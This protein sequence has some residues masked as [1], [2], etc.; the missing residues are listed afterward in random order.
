MTPSII[1]KGEVVWEV[2]H[3][4]ECA[5]FGPSP[6]LRLSPTTCSQS[7]SSDMRAWWCKCVYFVWPSV[8][9]CPPNP[10]TPSASRAKTAAHAM[11][12]AP[13]EDAARRAEEHAP[14]AHYLALASSPGQISGAF[15]QTHRLPSLSTPFF[16]FLCGQNSRTNI[17]RIRDR[18][19]IRY[20]RD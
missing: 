11:S 20:L 1:L 19:Y 4:L 13:Q 10:N 3:S 12:Q 5:V 14:T 17:W 7:Y 6:S 9:E 18:I 16:F 2:G 15:P 8:L